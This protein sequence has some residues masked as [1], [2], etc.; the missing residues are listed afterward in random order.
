MLPC[1]VF[2]EPRMWGRPEVQVG[3]GTAHDPAK[4]LLQLQ[5]HKMS[6]PTI[7]LNH[8]QT[9]GPSTGPIENRILLSICLY[10]FSCTI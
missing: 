3:P 4:M 7:H 2:T 9:A 10:I 5:L 1:P 6:D 8:L